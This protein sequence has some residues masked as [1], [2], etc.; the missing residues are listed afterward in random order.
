MNNRSVYILV[1]LPW[2][3]SGVAVQAADLLFDGNSISHSFDGLGAQIWSG[4]ASIQSLL[5]ILRIQYIRMEATPN[6][7]GISEA[8]PT[9]GQRS[10]F[11]QYV[12]TYYGSTKLAN[13]ISTSA[14]LNQLGIK[15]VFNQF[16]YL[17]VRLLQFQILT[18]EPFGLA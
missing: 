7:A 4:D 15:T 3:C 1:L 14:M 9:D 8:P 18:R 11:D 6:W 2:C 5:T 13:M 10:S 17:Q 16:H 12:S